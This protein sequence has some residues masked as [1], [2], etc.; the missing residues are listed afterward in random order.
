MP[1]LPFLQ[2][3]VFASTPRSGNPLAV[4]FDAAA[5]DGGQMQSIAAWL[6]LSETTF[7]LPPTDPAADYALRI[8]TPGGELPFAGHP[9]LGTAA[10]WLQRGGQPRQTGRLMQQCAAGLVPVRITPAGEAGEAGDA[11]RLAFRAPPMRQSPLDKA[12]LDRVTAALA[13]PAGS[14]LGCSWLNNG[15][16]WCT[17]WLGSAERVL[18]LQPDLA[19]LRAHRLKVGVAAPHPPGRGDADIEV[20]AFV[21]HLGVGEDPV[22]G[23][24]NASLAQWLITAGVLPP[25]YVAAQGTAIGRAGRVQIERDGDGQVWVGG[26]VRVEIEGWLRG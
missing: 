21:P 14:M 22:T 19:A 5:L 11:L 6:G 13:L 9:T 7:V 15:P 8:F 4:V 17:L 25:R 12:T 16:D 26:A 23:S 24:L 3:D 20:R 1:R 10:A 2:L 18:A